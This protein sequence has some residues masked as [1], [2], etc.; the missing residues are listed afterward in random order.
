M[1]AVDAECAVGDC[2]VALPVGAC[3]RRAPSAALA[4]TL[5]PLSPAA[6]ARAPQGCGASNVSCT[7]RVR[8]FSPVRTEQPCSGAMG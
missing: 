5:S 1:L 6:G 8:I 4:R 3:R 7:L 2:S